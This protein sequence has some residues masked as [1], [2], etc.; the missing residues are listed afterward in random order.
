MGG[1]NNNAPAPV[2][3][4]EASNGYQKKILL[5]LRKLQTDPIADFKNG[6]AV[7]ALE[8]QCQRIEELRLESS[9]A[10]RKVPHKNATDVTER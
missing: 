9:M 3:A 8:Q 2:A 1:E 4:S 10:A 6:T 5:K 7:K